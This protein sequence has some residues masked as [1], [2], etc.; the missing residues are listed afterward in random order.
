M[1]LA[2]AVLRPRAAAVAMK[3]PAV[4]AIAGAQTTINNQLNASTAMATE[5]VTTMTMETKA[6]AAAEAR[7][8]HLGGGSQLG[9][10]GGS[11]ARARGWR[12]RQRQR[13]AMSSYVN[14]GGGCGSDD[15]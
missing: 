2:A 9:G 10:G 7:R 15:E 13:G 6:T 5:T 12:C 1:A 14:K 8:Q 3:T 4:T 11:L